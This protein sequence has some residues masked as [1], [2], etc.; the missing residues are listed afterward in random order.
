MFSLLAEVQRD[1]A[2]SLP[3]V[4]TDSNSAV[5]VFLPALFSMIVITKQYLHTTPIII[6]LISSFFFS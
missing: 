6:H 4:W 2:Q 1:H 3:E 5:S